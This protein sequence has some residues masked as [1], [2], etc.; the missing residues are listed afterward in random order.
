MIAK[1]TCTACS[2]VYACWD[3]DLKIIMI[4]KIKR[5][6]KQCLHCLC[7]PMSLNCCWLYCRSCLLQGLRT[8]YSLSLKNLHSFL[9]QF[10]WSTSERHF[11]LLKSSI[12][13][14]SPC[15][16]SCPAFVCMCM[17]QVEGSKRHLHR[18]RC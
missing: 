10:L 15:R 2:I 6:I 3:T 9:R 12:E 1:K 7:C 16:Y 13:S 8:T 14:V 4:K 17:S 18:Y 11:F 5:K